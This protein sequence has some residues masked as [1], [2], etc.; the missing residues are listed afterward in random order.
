[1]IYAASGLQ[2]EPEAEFYRSIYSTLM[3]WPPDSQGHRQY[4]EFAE[5]RWSLIKQYG[6]TPESLLE[7]GAG[8][9]DFLALARKEGVRLIYGLEPGNVQREYARREYQ[10]SEE[11]LSPEP[12]TAETRVPFAP[13]VIV[14]FHVLEHLSQPGELL[15]NIA[16]CI[17]PEGLLVLEVPDLRADWKELNL[18]QFHVGHRSYFTEATL[19]NL[20][21]SSGLRVEHIQ[22]EPDGIYHGNLRVFARPATD[23]GVRIP[24]DL[25]ADLRYM[26]GQLQP[27]SLRNGYPRAFIRL[28]RFALQ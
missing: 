27:A 26:R 19:T 2:G 23:D 14:L 17:A 21:R 20:L 7:I 16:R 28:L 11:V 10:F 6:G 9:G 13:R 1:M 18:L 4:R 12:F 15:R 22:K 5:R 8:F 24:V 3:G 25:H